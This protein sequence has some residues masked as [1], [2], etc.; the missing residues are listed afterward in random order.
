MV[1]PFVVKA[2]AGVQND[3]QNNLVSFGVDI[4]SG[5]HYL[6]TYDKVAFISPYA[7]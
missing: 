6:L 7:F 2:N 3:A 1:W 4:I 5:V